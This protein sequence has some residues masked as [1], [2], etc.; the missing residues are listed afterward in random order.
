MTTVPAFAVGLP[1]FKDAAAPE[2]TVPLAFVNGTEN[3]AIIC[4][5]VNS[6]KIPPNSRANA[7][8]GANRR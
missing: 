5:P 2:A 1:F 4:V 8:K 7:R 6:D 3:S